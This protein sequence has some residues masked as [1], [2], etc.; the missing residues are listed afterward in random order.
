MT[1]RQVELV[2]QSWAKVEPISEAAGKLFYGKLFELDPALRGMFRG[3]LGEQ[4]RKLMSMISFAVRGLTRLE[5]IVPG[6]QALGRRHAG[7][8]VQDRHYNT[9]AIALLWTLGQGLGEEFTAEVRE[10][11]ATAYAILANTM[12]DAAKL[13]A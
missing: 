4:S 10:A 3:D 11:W 2:Q 9:V 1:P 6:V 5:A 12:R 7:Y 8:G 13:A